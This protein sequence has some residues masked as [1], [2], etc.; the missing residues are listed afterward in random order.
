MKTHCRKNAQK[1]QKKILFVPS[2]P[3]CGQLEIL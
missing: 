3:F 1:S 2:V